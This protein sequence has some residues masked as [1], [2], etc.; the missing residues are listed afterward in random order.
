MFYECILSN[1]A[2][3]WCLFVK[4]KSLPSVFFSFQI[5]LRAAIKACMLFQEAEADAKTLALKCIM[6]SS[7]ERRFLCTNEH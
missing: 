6:D 7:T 5:C 3:T 4:S 2:M 1:S